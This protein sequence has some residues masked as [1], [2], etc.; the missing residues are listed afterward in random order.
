MINAL[1]L[2]LIVPVSMVFG[3]GLL[4]LVLMFESARGP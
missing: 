2:L 3:A 1:W 4:I